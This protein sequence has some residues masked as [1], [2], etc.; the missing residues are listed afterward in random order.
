MI[1]IQKNGNSPSLSETE[2]AMIARKQNERSR[3]FMNSTPNSFL[4]NALALA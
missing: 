3:Q 4:D 2:D 1:R